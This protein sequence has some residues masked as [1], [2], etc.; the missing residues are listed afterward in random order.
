MKCLACGSEELYGK[1]LPEILAPLANRGGSVKIGG[2]KFT[3]VDIKTCWDTVPGT[4]V[5]KA[6]KGPIYCG[7]CTQEHHYLTGDAKPLR[8]GPYLGPVD[9]E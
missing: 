2:V 7:D 5:E 4:G 9:E 8:L 3:Q 1:V 6:V